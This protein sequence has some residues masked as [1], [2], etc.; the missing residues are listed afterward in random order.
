MSV[1]YVGEPMRGARWAEI[2]ARL[3]PE[4]PF[5]VHPDMPDPATIRYVV[6]WK[7]PDGLLRELTGLEVLFS[8]G[9]G[10]DQLDLARLPPEVPLVR[11]IEPALVEEMTSYV[12]LAVLALHRNLPGYVA[13]QRAR[14]WRA[15]PF[16]P[17]ART[18]VGILGLGVLGTA[19]ARGLAPFGFELHGWSRTPRTIDG[20]TA[21]AGAAGLEA[22]LSISDIL[23]CLLPLTPDTR[24]ILGA[25][26]FARM[27]DGAA[28]VNAGRGGHLVEAD[29][30]AALDGGRISAA[31][32]D[33]FATE[34]LPTGSA[35]WTHPRVLVTPHVAAITHA[36]T[37]AEALVAN[38]RRHRRGEAMLGLVDRDRGY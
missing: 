15:L 28:I 30:L 18:R 11:M 31:F 19:A 21:H 38:I 24:G 16:E 6:A 32:L 25:R 4:L 1:L 8:I 37:A 3:M 2:H 23:V 5:Y 34:P 22:I 17:A 7:L 13:Q 20:L 10:V 29:L 26:S 9:A 12:A 36:A 35:L 27:R 14:T 33:V